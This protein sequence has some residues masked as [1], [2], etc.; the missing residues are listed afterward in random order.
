MTRVITGLMALALFTG[1]S[2]WD[3]SSPDPNA[4]SA[5]ASGMVSEVGNHVAVDGLKPAPRPAWLPPP[6]IMGLDSEIHEL[7]PAPKPAPRLEC[8]W[9]W[10]FCEGCA[11]Q[12]Q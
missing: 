8:Q 10:P 2:I 9:C 6:D 12:P 11:S 4:S 1:W 3:Q 5:D 7:E